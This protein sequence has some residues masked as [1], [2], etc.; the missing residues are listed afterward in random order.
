MAYLHRL[1]VHEVKIDRRFVAPITDSPR[2]R[3]IIRSISSLARSLGLR[4]VA[5][6]ETNE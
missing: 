6:V 2:D 3:E 4:I 1:P 5:E